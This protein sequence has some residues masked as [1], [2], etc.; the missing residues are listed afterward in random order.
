LAKINNTYLEEIPESRKNKYWRFG[1]REISEEIYNKIISA[2]ELS[3]K[4][5]TEQLPNII[6]DF[7]SFRTEGKKRFRYSSCYERDPINRKLAIEIHGMNCEVCGFNF[8]DKYGE[9][10]R[11]FIHVHHNKPISSE[12]NAIKIDPKNDLSV[13]CPNC[14]KT[15]NDGITHVYYSDVQGGWEGEGNID[16]YPSFVDTSSNDFSLLE[17]SR[18]IGNGI[19]SINLK[20]Y[21]YTYPEKDFYGNPQPHTVDEFIDM[22]AIESSFLINDIFKTQDFV[23]D[24]FSL[25]QNYPNPFNPS[26]TIEF[27]LPRS[28]YTTLKVY[29]ILGAEVATLVSDKLQAGRHNYQFDASKL[30]SGVYYYQVTAGEFKDVR[31]MILLR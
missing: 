16:A 25:S 11:G 24:N 30:A 20:D 14:H 15:V 9:L 23:V 27:T 6:E 2:A 31:K 22:G 17:T 5:K 8:Q 26:T 1:V 19:D 12:T 10:G 7:E 28:E 13:L 21:W 18:C 3:F 4:N 29:T